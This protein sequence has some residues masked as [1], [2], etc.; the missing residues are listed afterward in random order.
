MKKRK[1]FEFPVQLL[2]DVEKSGALKYKSFTQYLIDLMVEDL[3]A[4]RKLG[5]SAENK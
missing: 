3:E 1:N 4:R 2:E 5:F